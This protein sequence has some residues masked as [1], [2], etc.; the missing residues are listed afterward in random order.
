MAPD[1]FGRTPED[2][3]AELRAYAQAATSRT[4]VVQN[5]AREVFADAER[6]AGSRA[7]GSANAKLFVK[8]TP[9]TQTKNEVE[10]TLVSN[11]L[12]APLFLGDGEAPLFLSE[13]LRRRPLKVRQGVYHLYRGGAL[14]VAVVRAG[15]RVT[16]FWLV[17][18]PPRKLTYRLTWGEGPFGRLR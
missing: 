12:A 3:D 11:L 13:A 8:M 6:L 10:R 7:A 5:F 17:V 18:A 9:H 4:L 14:D 2:A 1:L 16:G 15:A